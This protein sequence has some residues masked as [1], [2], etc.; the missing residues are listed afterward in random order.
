MD[1]L[2]KQHN[3]Q[4]CIDDAMTQ[5]RELCQRRQIKFTA[6]REQVLACVWAKHQPIGAYAIL[7]EL[8][9][10]STRRPA[11]PTVYRALDFLLDNGLVHRIA[12]LNAFIGCK[13]PSHH[14]QGH[15]L[16]CRHCRN[17]MELDTDIINSAINTAATQHG[18]A[19]ETPCVEVVGCCANCQELNRN[20]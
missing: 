16:I 10:D 7:E 3:H 14:H 12:S 6:I 8:A 15:F 2:A 19:V 20:A 4:R 18:F 9:K 13:D 17:A 5:A 1:E 11:P